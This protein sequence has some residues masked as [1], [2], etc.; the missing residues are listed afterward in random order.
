MIRTKTFIKKLPDYTQR[1]RATIITQTPM[2][3]TLAGGGTDVLWYSRLR[4]GAWISGAINKFVFIFLNKT[5]DPKLIKA[6]HGF[7]A[8]M[9]YDYKDIKNPIIRECLRLTKVTKGVEISTAADASAKS[10]LGGSGAFEVG[11]LHALYVYKR[12]PVSQLKLGEEACYVEI[13]RLKK[14]VGPQDQYIAALGGINYFEISKQGEIMIE[15]LNLS[16]HTVAKLE[17]NLLFF[18]T[19]IQRDAESVLAD[20]KKK[21]E[22]KNIHSEKLIKA[23]DDIKALGQEVK[24][25][26]LK[27]HVDDFGRSLHEH[28]L[29]KKRL[30]SKVSSPQI[31]TW[32][33]EARKAGALGGKI[34]GAGGG[35]WFVFYVNKNR[36]RFRE[37]M[38]K[39]GLDERR[40]RFD[41]E[42]TKLL[43]NLS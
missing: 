7:E 9:S 42:G 43:V 19:G 38:A 14:P 15:S 21:A 2:R 8:T 23:L 29:I 24:K 30:S 31:D 5:E 10:G 37:R 39:I 18:R 17:S 33:E 22:E 20:E 4:G 27:G 16:L 6:S 36:A 32:Y 13:D 25:Y 26:L 34:M 11:L 35:G 40:V 12:E 28:W 3:I 1:E 41:W